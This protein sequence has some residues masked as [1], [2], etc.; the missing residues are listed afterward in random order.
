MK[1][2]YGKITIRDQATRWGS[3]S[4]RGNLNFNWRLVLLP[5]AL[6]D[7]VVV[8]EL[9]HR[10]HMNHSHAFWEA[11]EGVLPDYRLRRKELKGFEAEIHQK[12][13]R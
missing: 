11:V 13:E 3:C 5:E 9:A 2:D 4:F 1:V 8:H 10:I 6:A 7:Y 12:Y